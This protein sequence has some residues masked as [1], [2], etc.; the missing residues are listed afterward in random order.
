MQSNINNIIISFF[1]IT[2][3]SQKSETEVLLAVFKLFKCN[4]L[5]PFKLKSSTKV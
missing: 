5:I 1:T 3:K 2:D 4:P